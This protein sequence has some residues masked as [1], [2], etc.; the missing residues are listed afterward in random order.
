MLN[1]KIEKEVE[2]RHT[3]LKG[4]DWDLRQ[5]V[6]IFV[7]VLIVAFFWWI[8]DLDAT[9]IAIVALPF[10]GMAYLIGWK[11]EAGLRIEDLLIKYLQKSIYKN[12]RRG[13]H[14]RNG[15]VDLMNWAYEKQRSADM[16]DRKA[17]RAI[18][19]QDKRIRAKRKCS[20]YK[21][22]E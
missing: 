20:K 19:R 16:S 13:Y 7:C 6:S 9:G 15:Y 17:M 21:A 3:V 4:K 14:T 12:E 11:E 22:Y 1:L 8:A 10:G 5:T 18:R 2:V